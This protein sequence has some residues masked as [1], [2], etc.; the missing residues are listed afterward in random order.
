MPRQPAAGTRDHI[1]D[2][3]AGL[4]DAHGIHA[5]GLQ[6]IIDKYGCGKNLLYREFPS[7]DDLIVAYL[8]RCQQEWTQTVEAATEPLSGDPDA[9]LVAIVRA[10]AAKAT[11]NG[12]RG[13]ALRNTYAEFPDAGHP[14]HRVAAD[15]FEAVRA[16]LH[17]LAKQTDA[18]DPGTLADRVMLILDGV[19]ANGATL[20]P[21][22]AASAAVAFTE[23]V[24]AA[25][26]RPAR[27]PD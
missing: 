4:F 20:G 6:Q 11:T 24:V 8:R 1:L 9:Q 16:L 5:V 26:T 25:A 19:Y 22:G 3:A 7:K 18:P 10:V 15:H 2:T 14:A 21:A 17:D 23:E 12:T 13:C 27:N